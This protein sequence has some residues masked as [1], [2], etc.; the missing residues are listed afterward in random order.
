[1]RLDIEVGEGI[2]VGEVDFYG[3]VHYDSTIFT[4]LWTTA[5]A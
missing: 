4:P 2:S 5:S 1:M 3:F